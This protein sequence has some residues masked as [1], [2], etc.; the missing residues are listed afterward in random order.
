MLKSTK[1]PSCL[2]R[3]LSFLQ[4]TRT[5]TAPLDSVEFEPSSSEL[6]EPAEAS[7]PEGTPDITSCEGCADRKV[8]P[9][10]RP[11]GGQE[12]RTSTEEAVV[13]LSKYFI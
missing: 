12:V 8:R 10:S 2:S 7:E 4:Q 13:C 3:S 11:G 1:L 6:A 9:R 5:A